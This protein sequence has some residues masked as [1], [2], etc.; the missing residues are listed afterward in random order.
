VPLTR[1]GDWPAARRATGAVPC[2]RALELV[3]AN[4]GSAQASLAPNRCRKELLEGNAMAD[5]VSAVKTGALW[6]AVILPVVGGALAVIALR[7]DR[8]RGRPDADSAIRAAIGL[9]LLPAAL[10]VL[11]VAGFGGGYG[12]GLAY[13]LGIG[14]VITMAAIAGYAALAR[15][16]VGRAAL[17]GCVLGPLV[18]IG[19]PIVVSELARERLNDIAGAAERQEVAERSSMI[20]LTVSDAN[21][22]LSEDGSVV[23]AV[24][25]TVT[26]RADAAI[27]FPPG[28]DIGDFLLY[29]PGSNEPAMVTDAGTGRPTGFTAGQEYVFPLVFERHDGD[30]AGRPGT[31]AVEFAFEDRSGQQY[32]ARTTIEI[33]PAKPPVPVRG[34][35]GT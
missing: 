9:G 19:G 21:P 6:L 28:D 26:V 1:R 27:T 13:G 14:L 3:T 31:W 32:A 20:R 33:H 12:L 11:V 10:I 29:P 5:L 30:A 34:Q 4:V 18:L 2:M 8:M 16:A 7:T 15:P 35:L 24:L 17:L 22:T 23:E 25:M